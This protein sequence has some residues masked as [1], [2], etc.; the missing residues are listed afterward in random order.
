[1]Q[2]RSLWAMNVGRLRP[3]PLHRLLCSI[4]HIHFGR[5]AFYELYECTW[6]DA[7]SFLGWHDASAT[8]AQTRADIDAVE[9]ETEGVCN[10]IVIDTEQG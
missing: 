4:W 1:M 8:L 3:P 10:Q 7:S 9:K 6:P 2:P 5:I